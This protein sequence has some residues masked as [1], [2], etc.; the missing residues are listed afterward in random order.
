MH[1]TIT[2]QLADAR[3]TDMRNQAERHR[4]A[5]DARTARPPRRTRTR[6][7]TA[8]LAPARALPPHRPST[9]DPRK[10]SGGAAA[11]R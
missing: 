6:H 9:Q 2:E 4:M 7:R 8:V 5:S 10:M 11:E 3:V 1:P